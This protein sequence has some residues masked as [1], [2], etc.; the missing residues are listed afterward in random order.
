MKS[1]AILLLKGYKRFISPLLGQHCRFHPSCSAY[2]MEAIEVHGHLRG[3]W[4]AAK[5]LSR[6]HP[7]CEGGYDPV[8]GKSRDS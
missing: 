2:A 7:L 5:R 1:P 3:I 8:P 4:L 6:C